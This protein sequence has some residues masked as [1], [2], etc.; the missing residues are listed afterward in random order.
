MPGFTVDGN[1][2]FEMYAIAR[3]AIKRARASEGPTVKGAALSGSPVASPSASATIAR[4]TP[5]AE[6]MLM[7]FTTV[8]TDMIVNHPAKLCAGSG[9]GHSDFLKA[10]FAP[11]A[12]VPIKR[13]GAPF[14]P[15]PFGPPNACH[16]VTAGQI[17]VA[18]RAIAA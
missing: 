1:A 15:V 10:Q 4:S 8:A 3:E 7:H 6:I 18:A 13:P 2:P 16:M 9:G 17:A 14:A 12:W 11:L 5:I